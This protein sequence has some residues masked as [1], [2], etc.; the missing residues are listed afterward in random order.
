MAFIHIGIVAVASASV[1]LFSAT[2]ARADSVILQNF[3][4]IGQTNAVPPDMGGAVGGN[5]V[6]QVVNGGMKITTTAGAVAQTQ[7]S[8][9]Q[10][11]LN[12]GISAGTLAGGISDPRIVFDAAS[13]R[14]FVSEITVEQPAN[15][16]NRVL[17]AVSNSADPT[18]GFSAVSFPGFST[19][20]APL[21]DFPTLGV[22]RNSIYV[23]T[24]NFSNNTTFSN[25]SFFAIPKSDFVANQSLASMTRFDSLDPNVVGFTLQG[26]TSGTVTSKIFAIDNTRFNFLDIT[27]IIGSGFAGATLGSTIFVNGLSDGPVLLQRQPDGSRTLDG[28]DDRLGAMVYEAGNYIYAANAIG[29]GGS[30]DAVHWMI[31]NATTN[32]LVTQGTVSDPNFDFTYPSI[33]ANANG[34]FLLA[35]NRAGPSSPS[36]LISAFGTVCHLNTGTNAVTCENPLLL[37]ASTASYNESH[38][39]WGDYSAAQVDPNNPNNFWAFTQYAADAKNWG[40]Q[41]TEIGAATPEPRS[42]FLLGGS[43]AG[44]MLLRRRNRTQSDKRSL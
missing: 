12:A 10:F 30:H 44:L 9:S 7:I 29:V 11:W 19:G 13:Q 23:G 15:V 42:L 1:L 43:F 31:F 14:F 25:V 2:S 16:G 18:Q 40:T 4:G 38:H 34:D 28:Q 32:V 5:Y 39:R 22:D 21:A 17:L 33:A 26:V 3:S 24:N 36:G 35:Y 41:I 37:Q 27:P 8:D 6:V 20:S